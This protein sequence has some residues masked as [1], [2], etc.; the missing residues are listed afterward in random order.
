MANKPRLRTVRERLDEI[1]VTAGSGTE[2][3]GADE[4][5]GSYLSVQSGLS[6]GGA[7]HGSP[8]EHDYGTLR[9]KAYPLDE[10]QLQDLARLGTAAAFCFSIA[11]ACLGFGVNLYKDLAIAT[12]VSAEVAATWGTIRYASFVIGIIFA[13]I[14]VFLFRAG[15]TRVEDIK[16]KTRFAGQEPYHPTSWLP[17]I[18]KLII[19]VGMFGA[20]ILAGKFLL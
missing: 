12:G 1:P 7:S 8:I 15:H 13:L 4:S 16:K 20:G 5:G 9:M 3:E 14:G 19:V 17:F 11:G 2:Q 10:F 18:L 6:G